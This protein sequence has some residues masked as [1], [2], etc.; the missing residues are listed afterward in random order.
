MLLFIVVHWT[1]C[2]A[3]KNSASHRRQIMLLSVLILFFVCFPMKCRIWWFCDWVW[4]NQMQ[5]EALF[6]FF[7]PLIQ[8]KPNI[9]ECLLNLL[10]IFILSLWV[11]FHIRSLSLWIVY[12]AVEKKN[13]PDVPFPFFSPSTFQLKAHCMFNETFWF[14][15]VSQILRQICIKLCI[16]EH[17]FHNPISPNISLSKPTKW[18][19]LRKI[20][21]FLASNTNELRYLLFHRK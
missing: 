15:I 9:S 21:N 4:P 16:A 8:P 7:S 3:Q 20:N 13:P 10:R 12:V 5:T 2:N 18:Q 6:I 11:Q 19:Y 1:A 17:H 14:I